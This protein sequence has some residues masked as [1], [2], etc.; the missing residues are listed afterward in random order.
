MKKPNITDSL[1]LLFSLALCI[2]VKCLFHA[3]GAKDDGS[4]MSCHW[5]EQAVFALSLGMTAGSV[6]R[7]FLNRQ[8]KAGA[9]LMLSVTAVMTALLPGVF[10]RLCMMQEMRCHAVMRP[11]V[12]IVCVLLAVTGIA[13]AVLARKEAA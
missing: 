12:I 8:A 11:A 9:A 3:C 13:D 4:F 1:L 6:L 10:I 5:A 7:L 2:G